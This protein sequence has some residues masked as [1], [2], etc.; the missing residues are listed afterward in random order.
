MPLYNPPSHSILNATSQVA[1]DEAERL[2]AEAIKI[3]G[4]DRVQEAFIL[5]A[6]ADTALEISRKIT[7]KLGKL[8]FPEDTEAFSG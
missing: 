5:L 7:D 6:K 8:Y 2:R 4:S 3:R 1:I